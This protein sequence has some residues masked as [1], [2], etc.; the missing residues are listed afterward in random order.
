MLNERLL[1]HMIRRELMGSY[2]A[3]GGA[4]SKGYRKCMGWG[5]DKDGFEVCKRYAPLVYPY[6]NPKS[7]NNTWQIFLREYAQVHNMKRPDILRIPGIGNIYDE[8]L[9]NNGMLMTP[10]IKT[11]IIP[12]Q[13][14]QP[15]HEI[16]E[17]ETDILMGPDIG[18]YMV[19][20]EFSTR[21]KKIK[22]KLK[23][24][25]KNPITRSLRQLSKPNIIQFTGPTQLGDEWIGFLKLYSD[26]NNIT[27]TQASLTPGIRDKFDNWSQTGR[28]I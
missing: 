8:W 25:K 16:P 5:P 23:L 9:E 13:L 12:Q 17:V 7:M 24:K 3:L 2:T 21:P 27:V 26:I 28:I 1:R 11:P 14:M 10:L 20:P 19:E 22:S 4:K 15:I 6:N 18:P